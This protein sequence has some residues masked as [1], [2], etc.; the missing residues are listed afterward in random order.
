ME[1]YYIQ[2]MDDGQI[3]SEWE[4]IKR[5]FAQLSDRPIRRDAV[6]T[7]CGQCVMLG[8]FLEKDDSLIG[9]ASMYAKTSL[10]GTFGQIE[11]VSI[12]DDFQNNGVG[13]E[14]I[15]ELIYAAEMAGFYKCEL[16][17]SDEVVN[18]Y[19]KCGMERTGNSMKVY[20]EN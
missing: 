10:F 19:R 20:L 13:R 3:L 6:M 17:C 2:L 14:I 16:A 4:T 12:M 15:E 7:S 8:A 1:P 18:F 11:N 9:I 5:L